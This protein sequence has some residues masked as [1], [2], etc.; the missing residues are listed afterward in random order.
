MMKVHWSSEYS[1]HKEA[2]EMENWNLGYW[3][4]QMMDQ[5]VVTS[6]DLSLS[7]RG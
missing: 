3:K 6:K 4:N 7:F 1:K 5:G 2:T